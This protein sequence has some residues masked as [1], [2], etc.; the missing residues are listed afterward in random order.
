MI[1]SVSVGQVAAIHMSHIPLAISSCTLAY[2][3]PTLV[4][5]D[6]YQEHCIETASGGKV[7]R[8]RC[9]SGKGL[10]TVAHD[11]VDGVRLQ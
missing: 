5:C 11:G 9:W 6:M 10:K 2:G 8:L 1:V 3:M 4:A 7:L